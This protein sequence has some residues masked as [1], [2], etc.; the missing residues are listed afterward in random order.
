MGLTKDNHGMKLNVETNN[1]LN[2]PVTKQEYHITCGKE[3]IHY[4]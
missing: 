3:G 2:Y 1:V 4:V